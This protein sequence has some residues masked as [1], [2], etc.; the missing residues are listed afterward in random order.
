M[1][2]HGGLRQYL[3]AASADDSVELELSDGLTVADA[4]ARLG[5]PSDRVARCRR[6]AD[7]LG[8]ECEI[9]EGQ[10]IEL[11]PAADAGET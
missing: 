9:K 3:P 7:D 10:Q 2:L 5:I 11:F 8:F 1:T 4:I 6:G